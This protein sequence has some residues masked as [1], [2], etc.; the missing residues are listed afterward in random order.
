MTRMLRLPDEDFKAVVVKM[1][2]QIIINTLEISCAKKW[3]TLRRTSGKSRNEKYGMGS[4]Q[5]RDDRRIN[6]L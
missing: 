2:Q 5:N 1:L 3:K 6:Q 4:K